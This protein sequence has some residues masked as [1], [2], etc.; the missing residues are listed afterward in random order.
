MI[1]RQF[2]YKFISHFVFEI[3]PHIAFMGFNRQFAESQSQCTINPDT[4]VFNFCLGKFFK[5]FIMIIFWDLCTTIMG[6]KLN[7]LLLIC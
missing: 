6:N 7:N 1:E 2:N 5:Y 4:T 3:E